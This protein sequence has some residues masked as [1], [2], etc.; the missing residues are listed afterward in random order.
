MLT[1]PLRK[2]LGHHLSD[3]LCE[4][5]RM[6]NRIS[7]P[8]SRREKLITTFGRAKLI[9]LS[10]GATELRGGLAQ[11]QTAAKEWISL[12]MHEAVLRLDAV[13]KN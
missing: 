3:A 1:I 10:N 5:A 2:G 8:V 7:L 4:S 11:D 12:F 6:N 9:R 13:R